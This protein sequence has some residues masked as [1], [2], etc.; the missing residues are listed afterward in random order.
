MPPLLPKFIF[1]SIVLFISSCE[2]LNL[3]P[4]T[5]SCVEKKIR[6]IKR[7]EVTNPPAAVWKW[8]VDTKTYYYFTSNCCD[9]FNYLFDSNC[10]EVC[11]PDGGFTG[12]GDGNCPEFIGT[13]EKTLIWQDDRS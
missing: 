9:Q 6:K 10:N 13:I 8:E 1:A 5:S 12:D 2:N 4:D 3:E 7:A 11:A